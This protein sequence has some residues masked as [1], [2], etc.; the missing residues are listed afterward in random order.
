M[1]KYLD[2]PIGES[3]IDDLWIRLPVRDNTATYPD[4]YY[5]A[6]TRCYCNNS[7][8]YAHDGIQD[9]DAYTYS[10][11]FGSCDFCLGQVRQINSH[12]DDLP[13]SAVREIIQNY[14]I[15]LQSGKLGIPTIEQ[16][17]NAGNLHKVL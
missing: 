1:T 9:N 5:Y 2:L 13:L 10:D 7:E 14:L 6:P 3:I 4:N 11:E 15:N 12:N 17:Q 8:G 16:L